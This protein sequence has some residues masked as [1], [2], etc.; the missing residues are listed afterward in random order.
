MGGNEDAVTGV[1]PPEVTCALENGSN[2][3]GNGGPS[4]PKCGGSRDVWETGG[5]KLAEEAEEDSL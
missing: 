4:H 1:P 5:G 2:D 3:G